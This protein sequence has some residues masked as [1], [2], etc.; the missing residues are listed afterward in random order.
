MRALRVDD[1]RRM[2]IRCSLRPLDFFGIVS[3]LG[4]CF[5]ESASRDIL[6]ELCFFLSRFG[7]V[8]C[9]EVALRALCVDDDY[10]AL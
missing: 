10:L 5:L 6:I 8:G 7:R 4:A 2:C 3:M 1:D 9:P